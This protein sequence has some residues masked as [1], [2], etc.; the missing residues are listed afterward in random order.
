MLFT[1]FQTILYNSA[2]FP[3]QAVQKKCAGHVESSKLMLEWL[4]HVL[5]CRNSFSIL[6]TG[7]EALF[8]LNLN[9][10]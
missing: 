8:T 1:I 10:L 4:Q 9:F 6:Q 7:Q 5:H 2:K 3:C